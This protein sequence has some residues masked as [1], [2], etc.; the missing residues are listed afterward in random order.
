MTACFGLVSGCA[1]DWDVRP[2]PGDASPSETS[3]P[4]ESGATDTSTDATND[5]TDESPSASCVGLAAD[6]EA[7]RLK[8]KDCTLGMFP[9]P[10]SKTVKDACACEVIVNAA[11][12]SL[13]TDYESA[14]ATYLASCTPDCSAACKLLGSPGAWSC[15][16]AGNPRPQCTP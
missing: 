3:M 1:L 5:T 13:T 4:M 14:I 11:A 12:T 6:V 7:A 9:T 15:L 2:D 10:C 16:T 8:A